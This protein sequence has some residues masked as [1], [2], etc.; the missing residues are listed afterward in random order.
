MNEFNKT[1]SFQTGGASFNSRTGS[2]NESF[3][4]AHP[5]IFFNVAINVASAADHK[6]LFLAS[7]YLYATVADRKNKKMADD[8]STYV[9]DYAFLKDRPS[10]LMMTLRDPVR[11][12]EDKPEIV[13]KF[14]T[15]LETVFGGAFSSEIAGKQVDGGFRRFLTGGSS[16][17]R[18]KAVI[19]NEPYSY[20][21]YD[22]LFVNDDIL[23][24]LSLNVER[25]IWRLM[26]NGS[27]A[28]R[29]VILNKLRE[30]LTLTG[31][32]QETAIIAITKLFQYPQL[33]VSGSVDLRGYYTDPDQTAI[34][35]KI[36]PGSKM[37]AAPKDYLPTAQK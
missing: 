22:N 8:A 26:K 11:P 37:T 35:V 7:R 16:N 17:G 27:P 33:M 21:T 24:A 30:V 31:L 1:L 14:R 18:F 4:S 12:I 5:F 10:T 29:V 19:G 13:E 6:G 23:P 3:L 2:M 34:E 15:A 36:W 25:E 9:L 28:E 32:A 20:Y